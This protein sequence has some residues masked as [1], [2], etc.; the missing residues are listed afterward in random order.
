MQSR[1]HAAPAAPSRIG[2]RLAPLAA[3]LLATP[4]FAQTVREDAALAPLAPTAAGEFGVAV[5]IDGERA[6]VGAHLDDTLAP[7]A[8]AVFVFERA[9]D[10]SWSEVAKLLAGDA[11]DSDN[12]GQAVALHGDRIL[13]GA[14]RDDEAGNDAGAAYVFER[15]TGGA[16]LEVAKFTPSS[17]VGAAQFG[18]AVALDGDHA[19]VG[20]AFDSVGGAASGAADLYER[21]SGGGWSEVAKLEA[22][23]EGFGDRF[24]NAV[25]IDGDRALVGAVNESPMNL[26]GA[27]SAYLFERQSGGAWTEVTKIVAADA[28][29]TDAF[30]FAVDLDGDR[31]LVAARQDDDGVANSG[32][33]YVLERQGDASWSQTAKL[34]ATAPAS[35]VEFG[36]CV[37]LDGDRA[38][39]SAPL[40]S[41]GVAYLYE[42]R[43]DGTWFDVA[44]PVATAAADGGTFG[45]GLALSDGRLAAGA[46]GV[47]TA[48]PSA[49]GAW[50]FETR[51]L[52][53]G[54]ATISLASGGAQSLHL[55]AGPERAGE[56]FVMLGSATGIAPG[57]V[58]PASGVLVPLVVDAYMLALISGGGAGVVG[59]FVGV[60]DADG[61]AEAAFGLPA[62]SS[63]AL[64]GTVVH[65]AFLTI[66]LFGVGLATSASSP[67]RVELVP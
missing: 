20:A 44:Q 16:W 51:A 2:A 5:D 47:D 66:D 12:F 11:G 10:G 59:P 29:V 36:F 31:A 54:A 32:S 65:H 9:S 8:G 4:L 1:T 24:G 7:D 53:H 17:G 58:D 6:V 42:R 39:V 25:A 40:D 13:V 46:P 43:P 61:G 49:G 56:L 37:R 52:L 26:F 60:L 41:D 35:G 27:G 50:I 38:A 21:Q 15:Q 48:G 28:A 22:S 33:V 63:P 67:A 30:G 57:A 45:T 34:Q 14:W 18:K 19:L 64:A 23:D 62:G 3:A 55:R